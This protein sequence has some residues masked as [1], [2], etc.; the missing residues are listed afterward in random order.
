LLRESRYGKEFF[1]CSP[2]DAIVKIESMGGVRCFLGIPLEYDYI[3]CPRCQIKNRYPKGRT[4]GK[5]GACGF[6]LWYEIK[7]EPVKNEKPAPVKRNFWDWL[8]DVLP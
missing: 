7:A 8:N 3:Y 4:D 1:S 5:C 6:P 2:Q